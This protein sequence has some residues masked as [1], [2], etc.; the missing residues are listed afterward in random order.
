MILRRI[1][2]FRFHLLLIFDE[3]R[4]VLPAGLG[5]DVE[6]SK[7][8]LRARERSSSESSLVQTDSRPTD[9]RTKAIITLMPKQSPSE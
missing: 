2:T 7:S 8:V 3:R 6:Q 4:G 9:S 1:W 5:I